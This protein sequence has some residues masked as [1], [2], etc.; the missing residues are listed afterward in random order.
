MRFEV[1]R[2]RDFLYYF[3]FV[4]ANGQIICTSGDGYTTRYNCINALDLVKKYAAHAI[5]FEK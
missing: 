4:A 5:V 2:G 1:F 3:R